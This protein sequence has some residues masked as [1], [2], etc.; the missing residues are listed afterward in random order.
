MTASG[1]AAPAVVVGVTVATTVLAGLAVASR[2]L[3]RL[4]V[5]KKGGSDDVCISIAMVLSIAL[6][7]T[8][9]QQGAWLLTA[10]GWLRQLT[11]KVVYGMG[12]HYSTLTDSDKMHLMQWFWA[13]VWIYYSSLCFT[14]LSILLQYLRVFPSEKFR[15]G[16]YILMGVIIAYS[17]ATFLTSVL[18]C[19]PVASFWDPSI[20]G[21][22]VDL[23]AVWSVEMA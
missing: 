8:M 16:C 14:K 23:K 2:L 7:I 5:V 13:S 17:L 20:K 22:C 3:T 10:L 4:T 15:R 6:T 18:A 21:T 1:H 11:D 12:R 9:C 19:I